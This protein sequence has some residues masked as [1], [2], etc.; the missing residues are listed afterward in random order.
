MR[1]GLGIARAASGLLGAQLLHGARVGRAC[2]V[3]FF[4]PRMGT[5]HLLI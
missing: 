2:G 4:H 3:N 1:S 5:Y